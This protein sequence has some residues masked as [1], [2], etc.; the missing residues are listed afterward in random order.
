MNDMLVLAIG[1]QLI[2]LVAQREDLQQALKQSQALLEEAN[3]KI[4]ALEAPK[5]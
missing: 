3:K 4:A 1:R 2:E 5:E